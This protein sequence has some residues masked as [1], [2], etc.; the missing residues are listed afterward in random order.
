MKLWLCFSLILNDTRQRVCL[1]HRER[2]FWNKLHASNVLQFH[3]IRSQSSFYL[4]HDRFMQTLLILNR[5]K[6]CS[7]GHVVIRHLSR[8]MFFTSKSSSEWV[9]TR[10][11][12]YLL[13]KAANT[14][15]HKLAQKK[16]NNTNEIIFLWRTSLRKFNSRSR[17]SQ[18]LS[19][20]YNS[21]LITSW[22]CI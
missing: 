22:I 12:H 9:A 6:W 18:L 5:R 21:C 16:G 8:N 7:V 19:H 15:L 13:F 2:T 11:Q 4:L 10:F 17:S 20:N 3:A 14:R 1:Q